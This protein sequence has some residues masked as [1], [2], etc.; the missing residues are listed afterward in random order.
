M[1]SWVA[2]YTF[3]KKG[4]QVGAVAI[5]EEWRKRIGQLRKEKK[6]EHQKNPHPPFLSFLQAFKQST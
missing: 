3:Y 4:Y 6:K 5:A 2:S 1:V